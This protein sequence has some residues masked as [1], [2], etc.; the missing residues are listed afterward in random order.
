[1]CACVLQLCHGLLLHPLLLMLITGH[2]ESNLF[3]LY[4]KTYSCFITFW[5]Q[6]KKRKVF[7][8]YTI[9][10]IIL[11]RTFSHHACLPSFF[12]LPLIDWMNR[13]ALLY[14]WNQP[15]SELT[16]N[17]SKNNF[18]KFWNHKDRGPRVRVDQK[19]RG[20]KRIEDAITTENLLRHLRIKQRTV[21]SMGT[22]CKA[23]VWCKSIWDER[24]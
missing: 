21:S 8:T 14:D 16:Y 17:A 12:A 11:S 1:M 6:K 9:P 10:L 20:H 2:L 19:I 5:W 4:L 15:H 22:G 18:D 13:L 24:Q 23:S 7:L 3:R